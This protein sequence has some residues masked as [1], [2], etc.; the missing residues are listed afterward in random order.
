MHSDRY[1]KRPTEAG[2]LTGTALVENKSKLSARISNERETLPEKQLGSMAGRRDMTSHD[3]LP[4]DS[5]R[6]TNLVHRGGDAAVMEHGQPQRGWFDP[7]ANKW[8]G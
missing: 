8:P 6:H 1:A 4:D 5:A 7:S 2:K 3:E